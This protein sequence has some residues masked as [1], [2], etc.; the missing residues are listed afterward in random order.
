MGLGGL[1]LRLGATLLLCVG[2]AVVLAD[3][4]P[5]VEADPAHAFE[6]GAAA[7]SVLAMF[8]YTVLANDDVTTEATLPVYT[9]DSLLD[10]VDRIAAAAGATPNASWLW[11]AV[12]AVAARLPTLPLLSLWMHA[13]IS[14]GLPVAWPLTLGLTEIQEPRA[15]MAVFRLCQLA[16]DVAAWL[17]RSP[18]SPRLM[19]ACCRV[20]SGRIDCCG[21]LG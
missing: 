7:P 19:S 8:P 11:G 16:G 12:H 1:H 3:V 13:G 17:V 18:V 4:V 6:D 15:S 10:V 21:D 20:G 9:N 2:G 14:D 5:P